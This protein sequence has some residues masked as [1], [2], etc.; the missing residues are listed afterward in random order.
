MVLSGPDGTFKLPPRLQPEGVLASTPEGFGFAP[1]DEFRQTRRVV[2]EPYGRIEGTYRGRVDPKGWARL[3]LTFRSHAGK[4]LGIWGAETYQPQVEAGGKF[5]IERVP[6]GNHD[7][8]WMVPVSV[9]SWSHVP[10]RTVEVHP[11]ETTVVE[12]DVQGVRITGR[13]TLPE[14]V[15][16]RSLVFGGDLSTASPFKLRPGMSQ[17]EIERIV[18][19]PAFQAAMAKVKHHPVFVQPDGTFAAEDVPTGEY[20]LRLFALRASGNPA[21]QSTQIYVD[22][23]LTVPADA[24]T[25][26]TVD[27]GVF[28]LEPAAAPKATPR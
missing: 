28:A 26:S 19:D 25:G 8:V 24:V 11:G 15:D 6:P 22:K 9:T 23:T 27:V 7:L 5:T 3:N 21:D 2:L 10:L 12:V 17:E 16:P 14:G 1:L 4:Y 13:F 18:K 20:D